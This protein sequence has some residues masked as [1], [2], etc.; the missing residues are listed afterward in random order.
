MIQHLKKLKFKEQVIEE[1]KSAIK[2]YYESRQISKLEY[3]DILK[4]AV[5]KVSTPL[6]YQRYFS[7]L[8]W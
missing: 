1:A 3:K 5:N 6:F 8:A 7:S 2:P 4:K